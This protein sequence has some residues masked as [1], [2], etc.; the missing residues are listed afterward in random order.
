[1]NTP[2]LLVGGTLLTP[3]RYVYPECQ[4]LLQH[5]P[6]VDPFHCLVEDSCPANMGCMATLERRVRRLKTITEAVNVILYYTHNNSIKGVSV[7]ET[8]IRLITINK[9][10]LELLKK[11]GKVIYIDDK[12]YM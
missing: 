5:H 2:F 3:V 11:D 1:M 6:Q 4:K 12:D 8:S 9:G 7:E 10:G